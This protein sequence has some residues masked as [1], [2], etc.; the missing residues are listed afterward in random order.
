MTRP[1][2]TQA[3][4]NGTGKKLNNPRPIYTSQIQSQNIRG[5]VIIRVVIDVN[6]NVESAS[7]LKSPHIMLEEPSLDA[8]RK[9]KYSKGTIEGQPV[10]FEKTE[11][12]K[13]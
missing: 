5:R 7:I 11:V 9:I 12:F 4:D 3:L 2:I 10:R 8:A 13:F 1:Y 6:G